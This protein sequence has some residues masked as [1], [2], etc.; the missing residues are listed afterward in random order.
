[1]R[2]ALI[3]AAIAIA[4]NAGVAGAQETGGE[5]ATD[6]RLEE[7]IVT[8]ERRESSVQK[9]GLSI[10]VLTGEDLKS[11]GRV[12][13]SQILEDIPNVGTF[14]APTWS[15]R[16]GSDMSGGGVAIRGVIAAGPPGN[17]TLPAPPSAAVY[18]DGV[19][20]GVGSSFDLERVEVLRGPQGTLY[21]RSATSGALQIHTHNPDLQQF[22]G[23]LTAEYGR[24]GLNNNTGVL[25]API[26]DTLAIRVAGN[27]YKHDA[28][29]PSNGRV[30]SDSARVKLLWQ[31]NDNLSVLLGAAVQDNKTQSVG[32]GGYLTGPD[33]ISYRPI[34]D[35]AGNAGGANP[36]PN[37][38]VLADGNSVI[39][40]KNNFRQY[41]A[42]VNWDLGFANLTYLPAYREWYQ[43]ATVYA[44]S[45]P[46][47]WAKQTMSVPDDSFVTH[48]LRLSSNSGSHLIWQTGLAY[49]ENQID[50]SKTSYWLQSGNLSSAT[51][52]HRK[53]Q[54]IGV[55]G[56]A[57]WPITDA[58]RVTGGLRYDVT[59][60]NTD[61]VYTANAEG[62]A[63]AT[64][65]Y[66]ATPTT[67]TASTA[68]VPGGGGRTFHNLTYKARV[69]Y[70]LQPRNMLYAMASSAF[71]PGDVQAYTRQQ[72]AQIASYKDETLTSYEIGS[73]NRFLSD[74]LQI[75]GA[76]FYYDY[77]GYQVAINV[78]PA[79][80]G[81]AVIANL[82]ARMIGGE[83]EVEYRITPDDRL[84]LSYA[85]NDARFTDL[86]SAGDAIDSH[87]KAI[88]NVIP[89]SANASYSHAFHLPGDSSLTMRIDGR[90]LGARN[91]N[92]ISVVSY[93]NGATPYMR[94]DDAFVGDFNATWTSGNGAVSLT[95]YVRNFNNERYK[96]TVL[97]TSSTGTGFAYLSDPRIYGVILAVHF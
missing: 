1:M 65:P 75:N 63:A 42:E 48:E 20:E 26:S 74:A 15:T 13:L 8:A 46:L 43:N 40:G 94:V 64:A 67:F 90:W 92:N 56:E 37:P 77:S 51:V 73:K 34:Y 11:Q 28:Y 50:L 59:K 31:P 54:D 89:A 71:A 18:V 47:D 12:T 96:T 84:S 27:V 86:T 44:S 33:T 30:E 78:D 55:F 49:Y 83:V 81:S 17:S 6:S 76:I 23:D 22:S 10:S 72:S 32:I 93:N 35:H 41:W 80:P 87:E 57:T 70:D 7:V 52:A 69:E 16:A 14:P 3:G 79:N 36:G 97:P 38:V 68:T 53:T 66:T 88:W 21:G 62:S 85:R 60:V 39:P 61:L 24:Y 19:Y 82:P 29:E 91:L 5:Q 2:S 9:S 25:N 58:L 95:G 4:A 45:A